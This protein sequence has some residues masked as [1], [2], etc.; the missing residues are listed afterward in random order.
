MVVLRT[1]PDTGQQSRAG[2]EE[3]SN[4]CCKLFT[5]RARRHVSAKNVDGYYRTSTLGL[6]LTVLGMIFVT[7]QLFICK[8]NDYLHR[9]TEPASSIYLH[10][11]EKDGDVVIMKLGN[12][13]LVVLDERGGLN[14][15]TAV[16]MMHLSFTVYGTTTTTVHATY[17]YDIK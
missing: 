6:R 10:R 12:S 7:W 2:A 3:R 16:I 8:S 9:R 17:Y 1:N 15:Y 13:E 4:D 5:P 11:W 14:L